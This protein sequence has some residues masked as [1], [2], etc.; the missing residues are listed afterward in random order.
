[1]TSEEEVW[2]SH[3]TQ[4]AWQSLVGARRLIL[5]WKWRGC[6]GDFAVSEWRPSER[7]LPCLLDAHFHCPVHAP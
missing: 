6:N 7:Y 5:G 3:P 2:P 1:M 4:A